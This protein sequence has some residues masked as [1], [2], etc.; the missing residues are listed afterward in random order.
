[1]IAKGWFKDLIDD[2]KLKK[3]N[4]LSSNCIRTYNE[5]KLFVEAFDETSVKFRKDVKIVEEDK[6]KY[7]LVEKV[8]KGVY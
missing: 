5:P 7:L 1:M 8:L 6:E 4:I 2:V 3:E